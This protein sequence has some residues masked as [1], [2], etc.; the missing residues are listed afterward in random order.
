M[1]SDQSAQA[2]TSGPSAHVRAEPWRRGEVR[3]AWVLVLPAIAVL[4]LA[5]VIPITWTG[6]ESLHLHDLRM[7]W[8]GRPFVG[9]ANY[10]EAI[11]DRRFLDA[12]VH[13]LAFAAA[14]VTL[15]MVGG[16]ALALAMDR[17]TRGVRV[18]RT[19]ILLPWAVP[20]V[21]AALI[22]RFIFESPAGLASALVERAGG[23]SPT[24]LADP[25][26]AWVP[27]V[28]ADV[29]KTTPFVALLLIA[30]LQNIDR[31]LYEA[32]SLDGAGAWG[33]FRDVT[34]PLL[35]PALSVAFLFRLLDAFRVF[36]IVYVLTGGGPGAST[37]PVALYTFAT[38]LRTLRFGYGSALS[39]MVFLVS[40]GVAL[41]AVRVLAAEPQ[42][43]RA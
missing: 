18:V 23:A 26:A 1:T 3:L 2:P 20:T 38:L 30:G 41:V 27:I 43:G 6:W 31:S 22:W 35:K 33:K 34:L 7:P 12:A 40:F 25:V 28:I 9:A 39:V 5:A 29:W 13:T 8:L 17:L 19:A 10:I 37:E 15:E 11:G 14:A 21:V 36:D 24:W 16:L 4:A 32:A 42:G